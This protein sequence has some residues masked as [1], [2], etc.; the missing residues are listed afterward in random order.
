MGEV[1]R[2]DLI[3][4][5]DAVCNHVQAKERPRVSEA[6]SQLLLGVRDAATD[7]V[8][9]RYRWWWAASPSL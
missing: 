1:T 7:H 2:I 8:A 3:R 9:K 6:V 4:V 5:H